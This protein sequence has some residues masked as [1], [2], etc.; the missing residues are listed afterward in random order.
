MAKKLWSVFTD[1]MNKCLVT[2]IEERNIER[3]HIFGGMQ[4]LRKT[5]EEYGYVVPLHS[6]VHPNGAYRTDDNWK[7]LDHWLKRKCQEHFIEVAHHGNRDDWYEIF[8]RFYDERADEK[9][10]MNERFEWVINNETD[11]K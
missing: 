9:V 10:W 3:H 1:N 11:N 7:D 5:A 2:G 8:G 6:S 4:G